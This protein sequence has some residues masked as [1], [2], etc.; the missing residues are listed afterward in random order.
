M[1]F[2]TSRFLSIRNDNPDKGT[3]INLASKSFI[4]FSM[5]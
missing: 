3:E 5:D 4:L 1:H 2:P